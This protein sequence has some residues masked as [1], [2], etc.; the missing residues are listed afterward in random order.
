MKKWIANF[1]TVLFL[2]GFVSSGEAATPAPKPVKADNSAELI[3]NLLLKKGVINQQEAAELLGQV[4]EAQQAVD[5]KLKRIPEKGIVV[6]AHSGKKMVITGYAQADARF[7][8]SVLRSPDDSAEIRRVRIALEGVI[9]P[10]L[11]YKVQVDAVGIKNNGILKDA[12]LSYEIMEPVKLSAGQ[13]KTFFTLEGVESAGRILTVER[14]RVV[15]AIYPDRQIGG[16]FGG[17]LW[18]GLITYDV[19]AFNGN[20]VN[21]VNDNQD[22]LY[23]GQVIVTPFKGK[24]LDQDTKISAGIGLGTSKDANVDLSEAGFKKFK[25][26]RDMIDINGRLEW[27]PLLIQGEW[28]REN[29]DFTGFPGTPA[30]PAKFIAAVPAVKARDTFDDGFYILGAY[31]VI[32][33]KLQFVT[34]YE[35]FNSKVAEELEAITLGLNW[36]FTDFDPKSYP[37]KLMANYVHAFEGEERNQVLLRFQVGY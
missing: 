32:P 20:G 13:Y 26:D 37:T 1:V 34:K 12:K 3:V 6:S 10:K 29:L 7:G 15:N 33:K 9:I 19:G 36:Y 14:S 21:T 35:E 22:F 24:I 31:Y 5:A 25:G 2:G 11:E 16:S 30:N 4:E 8:D 18:D 28:L 23:V 17:K 27:G